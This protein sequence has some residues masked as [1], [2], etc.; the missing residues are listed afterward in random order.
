MVHTAL[1][2]HQHVLDEPDRRED[3][4]MDKGMGKVGTSSGGH[5]GEGKTDMVGMELDEA[6]WPAE[7]LSLV[8]L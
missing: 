8:P 4:G 3:K 5:R 6:A 1:Q 7:A 2:E